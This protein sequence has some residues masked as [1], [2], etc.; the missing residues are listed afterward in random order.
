MADHDPLIVLVE[1]GGC[2]RILALGHE[3]TNSLTGLDV[4]QVDAVRG[5]VGR[6]EHAT[7]IVTPPDERDVS[8]DTRDDALRLE[9]IEI[10]EANVLHTVASDVT[11]IGRDRERA[12][13]VA[14]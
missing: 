1:S 5:G 8:A 13:P 3:V 14:R 4:D 9:A 7:L 2:D 12:V 11:L 6:D 10:P